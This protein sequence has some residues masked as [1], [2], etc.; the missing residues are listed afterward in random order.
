MTLGYQVQRQLGLIKGTM[1]IA[2]Y[3]RLCLQ[4]FGEPKLTWLHLFSNLLS[5]IYNFFFF[6]SRDLAAL[7][8][9]PMIT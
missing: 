6:E 4:K 3:L 2:H 1:D 9:K 5:V 8:A 7:G